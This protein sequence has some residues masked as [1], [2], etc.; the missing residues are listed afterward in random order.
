MTYDRHVE[1][2]F[3]DDF[4]TKHIREQSQTGGKIVVDN[5]GGTTYAGIDGFRLEPHSGSQVHLLQTGPMRIRCILQAPIKC[6]IETSYHAIMT[7]VHQSRARAG[8]HRMLF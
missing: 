4:G 2:K 1:W 8:V 3:Q 7:P 5:T 6:S